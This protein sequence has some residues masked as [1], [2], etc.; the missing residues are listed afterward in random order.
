MQVNNIDKSNSDWLKSG[1]VCS[2]A[3]STQLSVSAQ[4]T[5][6]REHFEELLQ[7]VG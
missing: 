3:L 4:N 5:Y 6:S 1:V 7:T 2:T